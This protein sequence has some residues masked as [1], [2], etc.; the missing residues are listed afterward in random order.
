MS[1]KTKNSIL[2]ILGFLFSLF[3]FQLF[4]GCGEREKIYN[5]DCDMFVLEFAPVIDAL[6]Y[7]FI[8]IS[9]IAILAYFS[10]ID[11][12]YKKLLAYLPIYTIVL[13]YPMSILAYEFANYFHLF[14]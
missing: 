8:F 2:I 1:K 9:A 5:Q 10:K 14:R 12:T 7:H 3:F 13:S 11:K 4:I 6:K